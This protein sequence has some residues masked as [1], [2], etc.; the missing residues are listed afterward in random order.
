[1][2]EPEQFAFIVTGAQLLQL[3]QLENCN[4][5]SITFLSVCMTF[6]Y[7]IEILTEVT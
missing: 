7:F 4:Y 2:S 5:P 3:L 6:C 1:M